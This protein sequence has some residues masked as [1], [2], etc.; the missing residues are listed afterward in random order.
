MRGDPLDE[1]DE[2]GAEIA[3]LRADNDKLRGIIR[4]QDAAIRSD[5]VTLTSAEREA[6]EVACEDLRHAEEVAVLRGLLARS[7]TSTT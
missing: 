1:L 2:Q 3:R 5:T 7:A 6:L 4:I